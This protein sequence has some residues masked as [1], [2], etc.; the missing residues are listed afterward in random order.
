MYEHNFITLLIIDLL[1]NT[2]WSWNT[3]WLLNQKQ[4]YTSVCQTFF[5][6]T[7]KVVDEIV[8]TWCE[9]VCRFLLLPLI[10]F[11]IRPRR[12]ND[13]VWRGLT[14]RSVYGIVAL[15]QTDR[16]GFFCLKIETDR[17]DFSM[18]A[19]RRWPS[20]LNEFPQYVS[21]YQIKGLEYVAS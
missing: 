13:G 19:S 4:L 11:S 6:M 18:T 20:S 10:N 21:R 8:V 7:P 16:L 15:E 2:I 1:S 17:N 14:C 3:M 5:I 9:A 12:K